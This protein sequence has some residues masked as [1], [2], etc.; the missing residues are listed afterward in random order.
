MRSTPQ[1]AEPAKVVSIHQHAF[2]NLRYIRETMEKAGAF[3]AVPGWG[4][5]LM[6]VS[7]LFAALFTSKMPSRQW[8]FA[9]WIGEA[10]LAF[11]IGL[12]TLIQKSKAVKA[13]LLYGPGRKFAL[14]LLPPMFAGGV[15][16]LFLYRYALYELMPGMWLIMYGVAVITGGAFSV[17]VVPL[18]GLSFML[19]GT[20]AMFS[21]WEWSNFYMGF[22]FGGLQI[23]FGAVIAR[24]Y[25]G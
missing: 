21:P 1:P 3:T 7:A 17:N 6:G 14:S 15:L 9:A 19:L 25:G 8:W 16:T 23:V 24:R 11:A 12:F 5:I 13:P 2:D 10:F 18:M 20:A 4:G 22:G